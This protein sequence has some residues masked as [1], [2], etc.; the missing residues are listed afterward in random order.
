[1]FLVNLLE[2]KKDSENLLLQAYEQLVD[3]NGSNLGEFLRYIY[4]DINDSFKTK[5]YQEIFGLLHRLDPILKEFGFFRCNILRN[6]ISST[7]TG[8]FRTNCLDCLSRTNKFLQVLF[9]YMLSEELFM[10]RIHNE[11][12]TNTSIKDLLFGEE[13]TLS[14]LMVQFR[15]LWEEKADF[16]SMIYAGSR[17]TNGK[18][19]KFLDDM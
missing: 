17:A 10:D 19:N 12:T 18:K 7:Q 11:H 1:M 14:P 15:T 6:E 3:E 5:N 9:Y 13:P 2:R 8:V 16:E 4:L